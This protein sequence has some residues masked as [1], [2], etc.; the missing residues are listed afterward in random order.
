MVRLERSMELHF[1]ELGPNIVDVVVRENQTRDLK[2][3]LTDNIQHVVRLLAE[4]V[5]R[6]VQHC[7]LLGE[8]GEGGQV[9]GAAVDYH[10]VGWGDLDSSCEVVEMARA[11]IWAVGVHF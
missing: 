5:V 1:E 6:E 7:G 10:G 8:G 2:I 3:V 4:L 11:L 9:L